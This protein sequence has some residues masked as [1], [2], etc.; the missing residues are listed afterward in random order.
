[1]DRREHPRRPLAR[2][3]LALS[4]SI[5]LPLASP[6]AARAD[7]N[8]DTAAQLFRSAS[9]AFSR[10]EHRAAAIGFEEANRRVPHAATLFNAAVAWSAAG[11]KARSAG[12]LRAALEAPGLTPA[13]ERDIRARL[14]PLEAELARAQVEGPPGARVW[15]AH[16]QGGPLPALIY[17]APGEHDVAVERPDGDRQVKRVTLTAGQMETITF[18]APRAPDPA[19]TAPPPSSSPPDEAPG[20]TPRVL[21]WVGLGTGAAAFGA[22]VVLGVNALSARDEFEASGRLDVEAH[23]RAASLRMWTNVVWVGA[24]VLGAAGVVLLVTAP[25][26]EAKAATGPGG[27]SVRSAVRVGPGSVGWKVWF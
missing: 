19:P 7:E 17:V 1:M 24:G 8:A 10:G 20:R 11:E 14:R 6:R 15:L 16:V 12:A 13:K 21:G 3:A 25:S 18:E 27:S 4:I 9:A 2:A 23:D 26:G 22:G 5:A